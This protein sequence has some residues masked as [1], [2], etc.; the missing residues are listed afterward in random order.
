MFIH[1]T[2]IIPQYQSTYSVHVDVYVVLEF[3]VLTLNAECSRTVSSTTEATFYYTRIPV[4]SK[5]TRLSI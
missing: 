1:F 4:V 5:I 2:D 3:A